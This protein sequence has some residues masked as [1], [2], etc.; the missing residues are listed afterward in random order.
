MML[1]L[2]FNQRVSSDLKGIISFY[3]QESGINLAEEF[4]AESIAC[5]DQILKNPQQFHFFFND[6]R[7]ANLKRFPYH[8]LYRIKSTSIRILVIRHHHRNPN[9]GINRQ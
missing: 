2:S 4:Q 8:I 9:F 1:P 3:E 7:R 5:L 6:L